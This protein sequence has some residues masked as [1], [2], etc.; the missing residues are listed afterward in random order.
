MGGH[1]GDR[2]DVVARLLGTVATQVVTEA[3]VTVTVV[4]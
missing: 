1:G 3:P 2:H 4:R